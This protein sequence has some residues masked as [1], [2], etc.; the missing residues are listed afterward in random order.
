MRAGETP[1]S[2]GWLPVGRDWKRQLLPRG[3]KSVEGAKAL[4]GH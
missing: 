2:R 4:I 3:V 1:D